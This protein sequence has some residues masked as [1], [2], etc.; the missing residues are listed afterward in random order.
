MEKVLDQSIWSDVGNDMYIRTFKNP[1]ALGGG[2]RWLIFNS[3]K[4]EIVVQDHQSSFSSH[5]YYSIKDYYYER[6]EVGYLPKI[7][8]LLEWLDYFKKESK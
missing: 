6:S 2:F 1:K 4:E 3:K 8:D 5:S 7:D